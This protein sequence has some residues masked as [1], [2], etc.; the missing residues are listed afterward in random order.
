MIRRSQNSL[1]VWVD[2]KTETVSWYNISNT[3]V[4]PGFPYRFVALGADE[5][6]VAATRLDNN[7]VDYYSKCWIWK[8]SLYTNNNF[9]DS[10]LSRV[11]REYT[12]FLREAIFWEWSY[13]LST[14]VSYTH[15][16]LPTILL[17]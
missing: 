1:S 15:L 6:I 11:Y 3:L 4:D 13:G 12:Q 9:T 2:G 17:V 8:P 10:D 7:S 16:T 5:I 14:P